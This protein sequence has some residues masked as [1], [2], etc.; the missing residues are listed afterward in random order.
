MN[1]TNLEK[2]KAAV[3]EDNYIHESQSMI[4]CILIFSVFLP[5]SYHYLAFNRKI[6]TPNYCWFFSVSYVYLIRMRLFVVP[7][8]SPTFFPI[9]S[10]ADVHCVLIS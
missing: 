7:F 4:G 8:S 2:L 6:T 9:I 3:V 1:S 10:P 5:S